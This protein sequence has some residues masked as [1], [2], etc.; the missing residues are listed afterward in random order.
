MPAP[1]AAEIAEKVVALLLARA[2]GA[3]PGGTTAGGDK[4]KDKDDGLEKF[5]QKITALLLPIS[6]VA[7]V[8]GAMTSGLQPFIG[9]IKIAGMLLGTVLAPFFV[10]AAAVVL[11]LVD[12]I[13]GYL[14]PNLES[15]YGIIINGAV[16]AI[17]YLEGQ[18]NSIMA[19]I[20]S[21]VTPFGKAFDDTRRFISGVQF[22]LMALQMAFDLAV[23]SI[24]AMVGLGAV[25][26]TAG[27]V[28]GVEAKKQDSK[29][30]KSF[31][32]TVNEMFKAA[33]LKT[34]EGKQP[35]FQDRVKGNLG[36]VVDQMKHDNNAPAQQSD[37]MSAKMNAQMGALNMSPY[38]QKS[39][40]IM[41]QM[42]DSLQSAAGKQVVGD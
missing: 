37:L 33:G 42:L 25:G 18:F 13:Q 7:A 31:T 26:G 27:P 41:T 8:F 15:F 38:E 34:P 12:V 40:N 29:P 39:L 4:G 9:A 23:N 3:K 36:T 30:P 21:Y 16:Q 10:V 1:T 24:R 5:A 17:G 35:S 11:S 20:I 32:Q 14:L 22:A 2:T 6:I 19:E 28:A